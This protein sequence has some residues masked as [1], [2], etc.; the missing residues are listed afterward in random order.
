MTT[1]SIRSAQRHHSLYYATASI[2]LPGT[3]HL[4]ASLC[5]STLCTMSHMLAAISVGACCD[6][7][8]QQAVDTIPVCAVP[9]PAAPA[10]NCSHCQ[11]PPL[12]TVP[13]ANCKQSITCR[14]QVLA[15]AETE[16]LNFIV[17]NINCS[18]LAEVVSR[19]TMDMLTGSDQRLPE[20]HVLARSV[21][22]AIYSLDHI[23]LTGMSNCS[24][25]E[26]EFISLKAKY[27]PSATCN[28]GRI[29]LSAINLFCH[30]CDPHQACDGQPFTKQCLCIQP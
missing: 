19:P 22:H 23:T 24:E 11:L 2:M 14:V 26:H 29:G 7:T 28:D 6:Q 16:E 10:A 1:D 27:R 9:L 25:I 17:L 8:M 15:E 13:T 21:L 20:L 4:Y 18:A 5:M 3:L 12:P 30:M